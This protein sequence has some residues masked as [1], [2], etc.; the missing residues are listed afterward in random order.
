MKILYFVTKANF[1]G[2]Q[3]HVFDLAVG[4]KNAGNDVTVCVGGTGILMDK[5]TDANIK[6][7]SIKTL[8]RDIALLDEW[9]SFL[10]FMQILK[11]EKPDVLHSHSSKAGGIGAFAGRVHNI[12]RYFRR[13]KPMRIVF[14]GHAWAFNEQ[15]GEFQK[16]CILFAHWLTLIWS[17]VVIAVSK[18]VGQEVS[19]LPFVKEKIRVVYNGINYE[20][21][22]SVAEARDYFHLV[23]HNPDNVIVVGTVAELHKSKGHYYALQGIAQFMRMSNVAVYYV[24]C[25]IGE[26]EEELRDLALE[27][28]IEENVIFAGYCHDAAKLF[29]A[30]D[31]F[32]F[33]SLTEAFGYVLLEAGNARVPVIA[34]AV[35]GIPEVIDDMQDGVLIQS[36]KAGEIARALQFYVENPEKRKQFADALHDKVIVKFSQEHMI[37]ETLQLYKDV[38]GVGVAAA[39]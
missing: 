37:A 6:V 3:R 21:P 15:R 12:G 7:E 33:P 29:P 36:R 34:S 22:L 35:G 31:I 4:A 17:D 13:E 23:E 32:L 27:L 10:K 11:K 9:K 5:L 28:G 18:K 25:G 2:A 39:V 20:A 8:H 26:E 30:F 38:L 1:C 16:F 14:T 24:L 19:H